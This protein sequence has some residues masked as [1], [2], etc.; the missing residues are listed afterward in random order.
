MHLRKYASTQTIVSGHIDYRHVGRSNNW[1]QNYFFH[2]P[3][4]H[5]KGKALCDY[6]FLLRVVAEPEKNPRGAQPLLR[7]F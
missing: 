4:A 3:V 2:P 1:A 5:N 7:F 6:L